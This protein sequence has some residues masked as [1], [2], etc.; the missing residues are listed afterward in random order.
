MKKKLLKKSFSSLTA[1][2]TLFASSIALGQS[3]SFAPMD[4]CLTPYIGVNGQ[5]RYIQFASGYGNNLFKRDYP[6][7]DAYL[8]LKF[9]EYFGIEG[10][11]KVSTTQT[12]VSSLGAGETASGIPVLFPPAVHRSTTS[13]KGWHGDLIGFLP[14]FKPNCVYLLGSIGFNRMELFARDQLVQ[15]QIGIE[16]PTAFREDEFVR[17]FKKTQTI[18]TLAT[19]LQI[20]LDERSSIRFKIGWE[21]TSGIKSIIPQE[22]TDGLL[23]LKDSFI[24]GIGVVINFL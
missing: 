4:I 5:G 9:N 10:G 18:L 2:L 13:F 22:T 3:Y 1:V 21:N 6:E 17:T 16:P 12:L 23:K 11:Y 14:I 7:V 15:N 8:G 20:Q 24:Y 19:G